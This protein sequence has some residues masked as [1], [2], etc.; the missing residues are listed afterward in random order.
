MS[1]NQHAPDV[2]DEIFC[3]DPES[4]EGE[5]WHAATI[6]D[7]NCSR[8]VHHDM[9]DTGYQ[10]Y[11]HQARITGPK[12]AAGNPQKRESYEFCI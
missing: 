1:T 8:K 2:D 5:K 3:H 4:L 7:W 9:N 12:S 6:G 11:Q 10:E